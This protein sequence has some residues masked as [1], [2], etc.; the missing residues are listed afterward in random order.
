MPGKFKRFGQCKTHKV[1][2]ACMRVRYFHQVLLSES[3]F[4]PRWP[5]E[6]RQ[7]AEGGSGEVQRAQS[8]ALGAVLDRAPRLL[9]PRATLRTYTRVKVCPESYY[10]LF[11]RFPQFQGRSRLSAASDVSVS[12]LQRLL[13][14]QASGVGSPEASRVAREP[15]RLSLGWRSP[16]PWNLPPHSTLATPPHSKF[17]FCARQACERL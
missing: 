2:P 6:P 15:P 16:K 5:L 3:G 9:Q 13:L 7:Q 17:D 10:R 1:K 4:P 11:R 8:R 14:E 12:A